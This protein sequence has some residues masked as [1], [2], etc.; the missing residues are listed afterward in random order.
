MLFSQKQIKKWTFL[1]SES[2]RPPSLT[3]LDED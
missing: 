3:H 2:K 1:I